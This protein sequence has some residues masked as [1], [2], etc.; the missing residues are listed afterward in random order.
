M[1]YGDAVLFSADRPHRYANE[2]D[3]ALRFIM[4]VTEPREALD[5]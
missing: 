5:Q 4:V 1:V 2:G 3:E